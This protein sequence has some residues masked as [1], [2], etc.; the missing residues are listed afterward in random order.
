MLTPPLRQ[1]LQF[2]ELELKIDVDPARGNNVREGAALM[3][4]VAEDLL[5]QLPGLFW[6]VHLDTILEQ[7]SMPRVPPRRRSLHPN[8]RSPPVD[9]FHLA[10]EQRGIVRCIHSRIRQIGSMLDADPSNRTGRI[11]SVNPL[12][13]RKAVRTVEVREDENS[14]RQDRKVG[15]LQGPL[16]GS[17]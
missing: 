11:G 1:S 13:K 14:T 2:L 7:Q 6:K 8:L 4:V 10:V 17:Q 9:V 16:I 15:H 5:S 12:G 3:P